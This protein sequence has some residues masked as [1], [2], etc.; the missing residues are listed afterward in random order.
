MDR[1]GKYGLPRGFRA[2]HATPD[3]LD[4]RFLNPPALGCYSKPAAPPTIGGYDRIAFLSRCAREF[5]DRVV[6]SCH[7]SDETEWALRSVE[8][9][10]AWAVAS[11]ERRG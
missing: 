9:A 5:A 2:V 11:I 1:A 4:A 10:V 6:F 3:E 7:P 8:Q